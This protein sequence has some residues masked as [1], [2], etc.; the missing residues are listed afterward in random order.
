MGTWLPNMG[1][2][3]HCSQVAM[4]DFL[5]GPWGIF[6][7]DPGGSSN[8]AARDEDSYIKK[9]KT[10]WKGV[11]FLIKYIQKHPK[12]MIEQSEFG[13]PTKFCEREREYGVVTTV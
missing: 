8:L 3:P 4:L 11:F 5:C 10:C 12:T 7:A 2:I 1:D 9:A 13:S 6:C